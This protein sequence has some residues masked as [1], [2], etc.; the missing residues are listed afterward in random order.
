MAEVSTD[1]YPKF[2]QTD[3]LDRA[4]KFQTLERGSIALGQDKLK[5]IND[6]FQLMNAELS[7][8]AND[9]NTTKELAVNRLSTLAKTFGFKPE[10]TNH[11]LNELNSSTNIHKTL[12]NSIVRGMATMEKVN[13]LYGTPSIYSQG[14]QDTP[15]NVSPMRGMRP[16]GLPIQRQISPN[17]PTVD[18]DGRPT[19]QGPTAPV[20]PPG[21]ATQPGSRLPIQPNVV[22]TQRITPSDNMNLTGPGK[23]ITGVSVEDAPTPNQVVQNRYPAP[24]GPNVGMSPL[25]DEGKKVYTGDQIAASQKMLAAKPAIQALPLMQTKGFLSGPLTDQFTKVVAGLKSTGLINITDDADP[26]AIRQEVSKKL[27]AYI[28]NSPIGQRSDAQ[29]HLKEAASPSPNVQILPALIRLT[30][31]AVALDRIEAAMPNAFKSGKFEDYIK[32]KGT[33]PQSVDEKA[34]I[35]DLEPE[36][37]AKELVDNMAK[38]LQSKNTR[39]RNDAEKFFKSLR[40]AKDQGFYQ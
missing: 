9:P 26:T 33:F 32:H 16:T 1:S 18:A 28:S 7:T 14:Q 10:V 3:F 40:M 11:M 21:I 15:V 5:Q 34:F 35:L 20:A 36:D 22:P 6:Q 13:N 39:E 37:K 30:K 38:K 19:L 25:F 12:E 17:Q 27:A 2:Q 31:D 29:Q 23:T 8:L 4:S 24:S